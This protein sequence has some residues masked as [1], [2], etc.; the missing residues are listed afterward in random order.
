MPKSIL[1]RNKAKLKQV[2]HISGRNAV[3]VPNM[4]SNNV[5][6]LTVPGIS[7]MFASGLEDN[8]HLSVMNKSS[9]AIDR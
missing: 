3:R 7:G 8:R 1:P 9:G 5:A 4:K 2:L 6:A